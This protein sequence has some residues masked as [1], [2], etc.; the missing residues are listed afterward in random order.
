M[1]TSVVSVTS[2]I[3]DLNTYAHR[4]PV[5]FVLRWGCVS[6]KI[7]L[8]HILYDIPIDK[9]KSNQDCP[10]YCSGNMLVIKL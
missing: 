2:A 4:Y 8:L 6:L 10:V 5:F 1:T 9:D 3:V 7:H